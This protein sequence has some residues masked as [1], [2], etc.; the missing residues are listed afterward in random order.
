MS[1]NLFVL[2]EVASMVHADPLIIAGKEFSSRLMIGTGKYTS[3]AIMK[4]ALDAS[5]A[6]IVTFAIRRTNLLNPNEEN[7]LD[8]IDLKK[9]TLLPNTAGART[10]EEAVRLA[11]LARAAGLTDW[12]KLEVQPDAKYL[13]PDPVATV[14]ATK[15]LA[16]EGFKVLPYTTDSPIIAQLLIAAGAVTIM[17]GLSP[18]GSGQGIWSLENIKIIREISTIPVIIDSGIGTASDA[19]M[20][21]EVGADAVLI[22]TAIAL[23][24]DPKKMASAMKYGVIAG[25]LAYLSGRMQK[26]AYA[27]ASSPLEG[28]IGSE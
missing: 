21:M 13:L 10:V 15:I 16:K 7:I 12:I 26:K 1:L 9:F 17:P 28:I 23:A 2:W 3:Y 24:K 8:Y 4:Q 5:E 20:A 6:E 19:A 14:E 11:R 18:I 25:R 22:N 27:N